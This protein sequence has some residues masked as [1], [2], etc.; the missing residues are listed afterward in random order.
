VGARGEGEVAGRRLAEDA[1][2]HER[3][4][5]EVELEAA[6]EALD[7]GDRPRLTVADPTPKVRLE[8]TLDEPRQPRALGIPTRLG[9]EGREVRLDGPVE[10][11]VLGLAALVGGRGGT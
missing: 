10:R 11:C 4:V 8:L 7:Y 2:E 3:V 6:T 5:V 9:E 1:V